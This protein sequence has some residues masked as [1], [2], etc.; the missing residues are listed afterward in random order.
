MDLAKAAIKSVSQQTDEDYEFIVVDDGSES[1]VQQHLRELA[2]EHQFQLIVQENAGPGQARNRGAAA[3]Q[4]EYLVFLDS[5]DVLYPWALETYREVISTEQSPAIIGAKFFPFHFD[6]PPEV[7]R[8]KLEVKRFEDFLACSRG[9]SFLGACNQIIRRK[10]FLE[11]GGFT[12]QPINSEDHELMLRLGTADGFI[13]ILSPPTLA[14]R[15]HEDSLT[16]VSEKTVAGIQ[17]LLEQERAGKFPGGSARRAERMRILL[18]H[19]RPVSLSCLQWRDRS[20]A[21]SLYRGTFL[22]NLMHGHLK[23]L[24]GFP[25][26]ALSPRVQHVR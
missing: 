16:S 9:E 4:G 17:F 15:V 8:E 10:E 7:S 5:D 25:L 18:K 12:T 2:K 26:K 6:S 24:L 19:V 11:F 13:R 21:W 23:Y 20:V 3:A 1:H 22:S 14:Y